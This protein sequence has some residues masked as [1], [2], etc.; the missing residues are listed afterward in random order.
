MAPRILPTGIPSIDLLLGGGIPARQALLIT[1]D[2][3]TGKTILSSQIA[4]A[5][6][7]RGEHVVV[8]TLAS[9]AQ[10]KLLEELSGFSFF[11]QERLGREIFMSA[12]T[13]GSRRAPGR[14]AICSSG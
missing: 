7:A 8:A 4:F 14:R 3:G 11:D 12:P 13:R 9:E 2:P 5:Q 1:G 6:A 10:D